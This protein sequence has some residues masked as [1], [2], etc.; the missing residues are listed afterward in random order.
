[1]TVIQKIEALSK[2]LE[3]AKALVA[4]G[5]VEKLVPDGSEWVVDSQSEP[6][7][8]YLV[9]LD[10]QARC[11]CPDFKRRHGEIQYCKHVLAA[12]IVKSKS[13]L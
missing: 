6:D 3:Q 9:K 10:G 5:K 13:N 11:S 8:F 2:R 4:D 12:Y 1:V 7:K